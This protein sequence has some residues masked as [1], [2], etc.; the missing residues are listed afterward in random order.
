[1]YIFNNKL[2]SILLTKYNNIA[3][4]NLINQL[5]MVVYHNIKSCDMQK[6]SDISLGYSKIVVKYIEENKFNF[7]YICYLNDLSLH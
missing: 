2:L 4:Y 1:M 6:L 7:N 3:T 5:F